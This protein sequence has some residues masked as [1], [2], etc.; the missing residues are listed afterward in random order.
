VRGDVG[1]FLAEG[2]AVVGGTAAV[3]TVIGF[4][5]GSV[6]H[7]FDPS[8]D[9]DAWARGGAFCGGVVGLVVLINGL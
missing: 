5:V 7:E 1:D 9:P 4:I 3:D 6:A 8:H 2:G